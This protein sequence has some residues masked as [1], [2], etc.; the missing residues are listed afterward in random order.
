LFR[1]G[2]WIV[3][4]K[5]PGPDRHLNPLSDCPDPIVWYETRGRWNSPLKP[6]SD[7]FSMPPIVIPAENSSSKA[8]TDLKRGNRRLRSP[9]DRRKC[10]ARNRAGNGR[11]A[12]QIARRDHSR[13]APRNRLVPVAEHRPTGAGNAGCSGPR[14]IAGYRYETFSGAMTTKRNRSDNYSPRPAANGASTTYAWQARNIPPQARDSSASKVSALDLPRQTREA[15][16]KAENHD[17][18]PTSPRHP[19][20]AF[21]LHAKSQSRPARCEIRCRRGPR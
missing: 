2:H 21:W 12:R 11:L 9:A 16:L 20:D 7:S 17:L 13:S 15:L 18:R 3:I 6:P 14:V 1:S 19:S 5:N 8:V 10:A 4:Q